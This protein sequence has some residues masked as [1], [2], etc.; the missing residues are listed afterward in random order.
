M[1]E[2]PSEK[3]AG[4]LMLTDG[5]HNG[6][7]ALEPVA[8]RLGAQEVPVSTLLVGST[9][10]PLDLALA[11]IV[12]PESVYLGDKVRLRTQFATGAAGSRRAS[13]CCDGEVDETL[14]TIAADEQREITP[15]TCRAPTAWRATGQAELLE[16]ELPLQNVWHVDVA[17]SDDRTTCCCWTTI[18]ARFPLSAQLFH[19]RD[20]WYAICP[21]APRPHRGYQP[22]QHPARRLG[23]A[24]LRRVG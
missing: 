11:D 4:V 19:G 18:R 10:A 13:A 12:A 3:L 22:H 7:T 20:K 23:L 14:V 6:D 1:Q 9:E 5:R 24:P 21:A 2:I 15:R 16:G 17:I 8:R